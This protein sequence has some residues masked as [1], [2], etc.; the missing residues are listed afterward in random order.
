VTE[1]EV[2]VEAMVG[3]MEADMDME[4]EVADMMTLMDREGNF[5]IILDIQLVIEVVVSLLDQFSQ[6]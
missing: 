3:M 4:M 2:M 6:V 1:A 5:N